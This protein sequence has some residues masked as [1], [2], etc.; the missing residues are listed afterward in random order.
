MRL[1]DCHVRLGGIT[2]SEVPKHD[3][4]AAEILILR[5][6]HGDDGVVRI[7]SKAEIAINQF[8]LR[9]QLR[10]K[11]EVS[12]HQVG[13][14]VK[15]LGLDHMNKDNLSAFIA[16]LQSYLAPYSVAGYVM[17]L[18]TAVRAMKPDHEMEFLDNAARHL[19]R[20]AKPKHDKRKRLK[21]TI[22]FYELGFDLMKMGQVEMDPISAAAVKELLEAIDGFTG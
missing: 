10:Y 11:Y 19:W 13:L 6:L 5:H 17:R 8:E 4:T 9:D 22:E 14:I 12:E 7:V 1:Y 18:A 2:S 15:V 20:T 3:I 16:R 21:P